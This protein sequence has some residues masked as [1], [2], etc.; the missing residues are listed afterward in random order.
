MSPELSE[1]SANS[2]ITQAPHKRANR[3]LAPAVGSLTIFPYPR[4]ESLDSHRKVILS[5]DVSLNLSSL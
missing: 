2:G 1:N 5:V 3:K 4:H